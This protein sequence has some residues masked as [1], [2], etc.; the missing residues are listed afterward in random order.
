MNRIVVAIAVAVI[1]G[2]VVLFMKCGGTGDESKSSKVTTAGS[3]SSAGA[4]R[5]AREEKPDP[6]T[7]ARVAIHGTVTVKGGGPLAGAQVCTNGHV[8]HVPEEETRD[9]RCVITD[10]KGAYGFDE[11]YAGSYWVSASAAKHIPAQWRGPAPD[12]DPTIKLAAGQRRDDIDLALKPGGVEVKGTVSDING[13]PIAEA[14]V[15]VSG[16][17]WWERAASAT[18]RS[19]ADGTFTAWT[20]PG[21]VRATATADGYSSGSA[22]GKA[23]TTKLDILL[24]PESVL[25]GTVVEAETGK[26]VAGANVSAN[27]GGRFVFFGDG[28]GPSGGGTATSDDQGKFRIARLAPGR[29]K[30][31]AQSLGRYG[32]PADSVLLGL[33]QT[34]EGVII[35]VHAVRVVTGRLVIDDGSTKLA[36]CG[37]GWVWV[38][39]KNDRRFTAATEDDGAVRFE[40]ILP[41]TYTVSARCEGY[42]EED[43]YPK[44]VVEDVDVTGLEWKVKIGGNF[45]GTVKTKAGTPLADANV[46]A[47]T[48]G[49]DPRGQRSWGNA[50][51][52]DDGTYKVRGVAPGEYLLDVQA[53]DHP[54][55]KDPMKATAVAGQ[56]VTADIVVD[57]GG[58]ITGVVVDDRGAAVPGA[59]VM[60]MGDRWEWRGGG[61]RTGDDGTF[62]LTGLLPGSYRVTASRGWTDQMR[63]PGST[64]DDVQ[65]ERATVAIGQT[66]N[67]RIV[68]EGQNGFIAGTVVDAAGAPVPDAYLA[69]ERESD[70]AGAIAGS[71][72]RQSRWGW[73]R[74]PVVTDASGAFKVTGLSDG[75][76]TVRAY[77]KGGGEAITEHVAVGTTKAKLVLK[78]TGS[79]TGRVT[80]KGGGVADDVQVSASDRTTGF[81]RS[82]KFFRTDGSFTIA[83]LPAGTFTIRASAAQGQVDTTVTLAEGERKTG[84]TLELEPRV[85]VKGRLIALD[86]GKPVPGLQVMVL[87]LKGTGADYFIMGGGSDSKEMISDA[88]GRF[89]VEDAPAGRVNIQAWA[90]DWEES[91]YGFLRVARTLAGGGEV[92]VGELKV[93]RRRTGPRDRGSDLGFDL[94]EQPPDVEPEDVTYEVSRIRPGGPAVGSGLEVGDVI[95]S[96]DGTDVKGVNSYL[97]WS[98]W[99]VPVGTKMSLGLARGK[100]ISI[101]TVPEP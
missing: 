53:E 67:V 81:Q 61:E 3:S 6:R 80:V 15:A 38:S 57:D 62:E 5:A 59:R 17:E 92:D 79:V 50:T 49:G 94:K 42:L 98:L 70:A 97:A 19:A 99:Q 65:G 84:I 1:A 27:A 39:G 35:K 36:G 22:G 88:D 89:T 20:A 44:L 69:T 64:D 26:P 56:D 63:K 32:E 90:V 46:T 33:G 51:S 18:T 96:I 34:V 74:K 45:V 4:A 75:K 40:A 86:D 13:G 31:S 54:T 95:V 100:T 43:V 41:G 66:A 14:W 37:K 68:V 87:P 7:I 83:D 71:A 8:E 25:A 91:P 12:R 52:E 9:P 23:P 16:G 47:R 85:T 82:E 72:A 78:P 93:A 2:A 30:P 77:R 55:P 58:T 60:A 21:G 10:A 48:V 28:D 73:D 76:Y 24:T 29:Y 11:L 101:T